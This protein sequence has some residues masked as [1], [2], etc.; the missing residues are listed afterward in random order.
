MKNRTP[1][2]RALARAIETVGGQAALA[3][4]INVSQPAIFKWLQHPRGA[5][6]ERTIDIERATGVPRHELRP[7]LWE[8]AA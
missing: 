7:D 1:Q 3:R 6:A 2:Q 4:I 8:N 5:P